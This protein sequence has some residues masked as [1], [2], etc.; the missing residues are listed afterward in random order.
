[1][2]I[3][4][5]GAG[6]VG[7]HLASLL[8]NEAHE[9]TI[10]DPDKKKLERLESQLDIMTFKGDTSSFGILEEASMETTDIFIAVTDRQNTNLIACL[11]AKKLGAKKVIARV[12]NPEYLER[13][14]AMLM[15]RSGVDVLISP[16]EQAANE[17]VNLVEASILSETHTFGNRSLHLFA[18]LLTEE[19]PIIGKTVRE[20][21]DE[22]QKDEYSIFSPICL[23]RKEDDL[24]GMC[25]FLKD[26]DIFQEGDRVYFLAI[27]SARNCIYELSGKI[28]SYLSDVIILGGG[29]I[30]RKA[31]Q[32]LQKANHRVKLVERDRER[33]EDLAG[34]LTDIMVLQADGRDA[35]LMVEEGIGEADAFIAVTGRSE[36]N[37]V[38]CLLAKS[39]GVTKNIA[40]INNTDYI[41]LSQAVGIDSFINQKQLTANAILKYVRKGKVLDVINLSDMNTVVMEFR[42]SESS[43]L[44]G[45]DIGDLELPDEVSIG[46]VVRNGQ[47]YI[48]NAGLVVEAYDR[49]IIFSSSDCMAT[50]ES[51]F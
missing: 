27:E 11:I 3:V 48:A 49:I 5:G 35:D 4:I 25:Q 8:A 46:G 9:I 26:E 42:V 33:A 51:L 2:K 44:I 45:Q 29:N 32:L 18:V 7:C 19:S 40:L 39:K 23:M 43:P 1:M 36:T 24:W 22:Y 21:I 31:A 28:Q 13:K 16:E 38:A 12:K 10:I 20:V 30:G 47:G 6:D 50:V 41:H 37:M 17:V 15:H 14:N 34:N